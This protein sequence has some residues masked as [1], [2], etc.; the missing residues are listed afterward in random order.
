MEISEPK[1]EPIDLSEILRAYENKWIVLSEDN[2][3]VIASGD[4]IDDLGD[5]VYEGVIFRVP[6]FDAVFVPLI[7]GLH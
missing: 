2:T 4:S 5:R 6:R 3:C 7:Y 1:I